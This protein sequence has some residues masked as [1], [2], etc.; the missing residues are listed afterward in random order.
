MPRW[1]LLV[2]EEA[3]A[4]LIPAGYARFARPICD[5]LV[6]FLRGLAAEHQAAIVADQ[7]ALPVGASF[8]ERLGRLACSCPALQKLGQ[9]LSRDPRLAPELK[10]QLQKLESLPPS[11]PLAQIQETLDRELGPLER[12]G[13]ELLPPAL[14][15]ASVAVVIPMRVRSPA[16]GSC[17]DGVFKIL[18][19]GIEQR[20][21]QEL[22]L[23]ER[24]GEH[25]DQRCDE[26]GIPHLD[27]RESFQQVR[28]KLQH[29]VRLDLEQQHLAAARVRY[30]DQPR[31]LIP[32]LLR[33]CTARVTAM[34]R[35]RGTKVTADSVPRPERL[36]L[37]QLAVET[38]IARPL[39]S[40]V[41]PSTFHGDP[42]AGNLFRAADGRLAILDWS[43]VG[44]LGDPQRVA[45]VQV[46]LGALALDAERIVAALIGLAERRTVDRSALTA[47]VHAGLRRVRRGA[48]IG[49]RWLTDLLDEAVQRGRLRVGGD[50]MLFRKMLHTLEGVVTELGLAAAQVDAVLFQAFLGD[51]I[52]EWPRRWLAAPSSRAFATRLSNTDLTEC[53]L[54]WPWTVARFWLGESR[55]VWDGM[56]QSPQPV[57]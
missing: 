6:V 28:E 1:E 48:P 23:L 16:R 10:E 45:M 36:R 19:P 44:S 52:S 24:V 42:H 7:A 33:H 51:L 37:A 25:L 29:E 22:E 8:S 14:A 4:A 32:E 56:Y 57:K 55:D 31:V 12:R 41:H 3:L 26:L 47:V 17:G 53:M 43:L 50:L 39:L 20:L 46:L 5:G 54:G 38:L 34:E 49:L 2:D 18:K 27:Y 13:I 11:V 40:P 35:V 15:E 30:A 9:V 21:D